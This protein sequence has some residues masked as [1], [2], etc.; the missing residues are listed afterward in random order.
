MTTNKNKGN[1]YSDFSGRIFHYFNNV[2]NGS[3]FIESV[4]NLIILSFI[5]KLLSQ[6]CDLLKGNVELYVTVVYN[7]C[8]L[9][10]TSH[11]Q[12]TN[13]LPENLCRLCFSVTHYCSGLFSQL[14]PAQSDV[15]ISTH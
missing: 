12:V 3:L 8:V 5:S 2:Q 11:T 10:I 4:T 7:L 13:L 15:N 9:S 6:Y 14:L 1:I